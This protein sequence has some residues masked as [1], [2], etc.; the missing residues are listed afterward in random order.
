MVVQRDPRSVAGANGA[1][2]R[3]TKWRFIYNAPPVCAICGAPVD[4]SLR[5]PHPMAPS[6]DHVTPLAL[7][8]SARDVS[9]W[10][11]AHLSCNQAKGD[12]LTIAPGTVGGSCLGLD[13]TSRDHTGDLESCP[14]GRGFHAGVRL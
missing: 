9:N 1:V 4:K 13:H 8:G 7:G 10:Q 12:R 14:L 5:F 11:L 2:Y 3:R 6:V